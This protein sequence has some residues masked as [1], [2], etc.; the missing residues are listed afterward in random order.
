M[1]TEKKKSLNIPNPIYAE[2]LKKYFQVFT[3]EV[4]E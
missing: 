3:F 4:S 2:H 1:E